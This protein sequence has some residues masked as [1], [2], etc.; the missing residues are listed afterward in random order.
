MA[1]SN[2]LS[3]DSLLQLAQQL[4]SSSTS[5][6]TP[7]QVLALLIHAIHSA[8]SF[9][10]ITPEPA[11]S[12]PTELS[13]ASGETAPHPNTLPQGWPTKDGEL[14]F[15]YKHDQSSLEYVVSVVQLGDRALVAGVAVQNP[16]TSSTFDFLL[17]DYFSPTLLSPTSPP[18]SLSSLSPSNPFSAP[19][20][21]TDLILL[22]RLNILQKLIPGL[23]KEGYSEVSENEVQGG[24]SG[25]RAQAGGVGGAVPP[26]PLAGT[27]GYLPDRGGAMGMFPPA[28]PQRDPQP[29]PGPS[30]GGS[31]PSPA[32]PPG[33][34]SPYPDD[35][36]RI[37][38]RGGGGGIGENPLAGIGRRDLDPLGGMG[39]TFGGPSGFPIP[40]GL[41]GFGG[42]MGGMGGGGGGMF[43]GPDHPLFRERFGSDFE[44][45]GAGA[46]R[47]GGDGYLPE[48]GAPVGARFD[49]VGPVNGPPGGS[50]LGV[51]PGQAGFQ[52]GPGAGGAQGGGGPFS[53]GGGG[54]GRGRG[55]V[56]PDLE[57]P[58]ADSEWQNSMFG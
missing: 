42:G 16:R 19:H 43:M 35:P 51:G 12:T 15:K 49:P 10:L 44:G 56:H 30:R 18:L 3:P 48:G 20:R 23:R 52:P 45:G 54:G 31:V 9:R 47:W 37:P 57:R 39:G 2:A 27:G 8:L 40:G 7:T 53:G 22:Y 33:A 24:A 46:R 29:Q 50:G 28:S 17:T 26:P 11:S 4:V 36:L 21:L 1:G 58:G 6:S 32:L 14:K 38:G 41:G 13:Q 55:G 25:S 5:L 34:P